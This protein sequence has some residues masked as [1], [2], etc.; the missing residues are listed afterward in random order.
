MSSEHTD[1]LIE[2]NKAVKTVNFYPK[3]HPKLDAA[4]GSFLSLLR[5][6]TAARGEIRWKV[7]AK[8][9]Y[10]GKTPIAATLPVST[11]L[12][13]KLFLRKVKAV[14]FLPSVTLSDIKAFLQV[15]LLEPADV[16]ARG[17]VEKMLA[18]EGAT[19]GILLNEMS[20]K[21]LEDLK[22]ELK[23]E[24]LVA[25]KKVDQELEAGQ[26]DEGSRMKQELQPENAPE[27]E[28]ALLSLLKRIENE[29]DAIKYN[30]IAIRVTEKT[31]ALIGR[32]RF[33]EAMPVLFLFLKHTLPKYMPSEEMRKK[34]GECISHYLLHD[35]IVY[36]VKTVTDKEEPERTA[37][38]QLILMG[39]EDV[40]GIL[41]DALIETGEANRR[42]YL[43]NILVHMGEKIRPMVVKRIGDARWYVVRQMV[44]LIGELGGEESIEPLERAYGHADLRVKKEVLK[45]L[46][47]IPTTRSSQILMSALRDGDRG[48]MGQA[49][50]SIGI[51]RNA[52]AV[53][54]LGELALK[55]EAFADNSPLRK[56]AVKALGT[57]G[58]R[59]AVP[60][61]TKLLFKKVWFGRDTNEELRT[62]AVTALGKIGGKD[63]MS[64]VKEVYDDSTGTLYNTCKRVLEGSVGAEDD[65]EKHGTDT[66]KS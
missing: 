44:T 30:D 59:K 22:N 45:A 47:R 60:Y 31:D 61:L 13:R 26:K 32:R 41:L 62:L 5:E 25:S 12:A 40:P 43:F 55:R 9:I 49:I 65:T 34:A 21:D 56:E 66:N 28:E 17:G 39:G 27:E 6:I 35:F 19:G 18:S 4:L 16:F 64:A 52:A 54:T 57:I 15:L 48:I 7:D 2:L 33:D 8:C 50:I 63:A 10:S 38:Q 1:I 11:T 46:A 24:A 36:L 14:R 37:V 20:Y 29:T 58:D 51:L 42:R 53:D 23:D 3:W